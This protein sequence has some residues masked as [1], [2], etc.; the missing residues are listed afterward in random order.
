MADV[1]IEVLAE[2]IAQHHKRDDL[3]HKEMTKDIKEVINQLKIL[4][5]KVA[6]HERFINRLKG[7]GWFTG[8]AS[9]VSALVAF[10]LW[11]GGKF[12]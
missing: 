9:A 3:F 2:R 1:T 6:E 12:R 11:I 5:G 7:A 10:V 4:N 8:V